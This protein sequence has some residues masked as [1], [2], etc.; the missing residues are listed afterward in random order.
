MNARYIASAA[1]TTLCLAAPTVASAATRYAEP[2]GDG[3]AATCPQ[4]DPCDLSVAVEADQVRNGDEIVVLP[5]TYNLGTTGD[6]TLYLT[7]SI[8]VHGQTGQADPIISVG[9]LYGVWSNNS[10]A[11]LSRVRVDHTGN[12][13]A[14]Y[15]MFGTVER[16]ISHAT[17]AGGAACG[18]QTSVFRDTVC[19][20]EGAHG[21]GVGMSQSSGTFTMKLRNVTAIGEGNLSNATGIRLYAS[22]SADHTIDAKGVIADSPGGDILVTADASSKATVNLDHSSYTNAFLFG[23]GNRSV[24]APGSGSNQTAAPHFADAAAGD[25]REAADSPTVDAGVVDASSGAF[26]L[27]DGPRT[28]GLAPDIGAYELADS[29]DD[30]DGAG[31]GT[32]NCALVSNPGQA[33]TDSDGA[34]DACDSDDDN[35]TVGDGADNC[36]LVAN[37]SQADVDNDGIGDACDPTDDRPVPPTP[38]AETPPGETPPADETAVPEETVNP[39]QPPADDGVDRVAPDTIVDRGPAKR[40]LKRRALVTFRSSEQ[41]ARFECSLD[42]APFTDCSSPLRVRVTRG[43]RHRLEVRAIDAAANVDP[44]PAVLR[45]RV[46]AR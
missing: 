28:D 12:A 42:R 34:G 31:D 40:T 17:S 18:G 39:E 10:G 22:T 37:S 1:L 46:L 8:H 6:D 9:A 4:A 7:K 26:D 36:A 24:T 43:Y 19:W 27:G 38:P 5:G 2:G 20:A 16:V 32:D 3:P 14:V 25:F 30:D 45:W 11:K 44:T 13:T 33:D 21:A 41:G 29:D 35:D 15:F 23:P